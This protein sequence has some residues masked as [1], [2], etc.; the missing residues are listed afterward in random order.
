MNHAM[1][2]RIVEEVA[3]RLRHRALSTAHAQRGPARRSGYPQPAV[4]ARFGWRIVQVDL[5]LLEQLAGQRALAAAGCALHEAMA[6][7]V[8]VQLTLLPALLP[9]RWR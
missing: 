4:P 5:P 1:L 8:R 6:W 7:G 9:P 3:A 2:Q